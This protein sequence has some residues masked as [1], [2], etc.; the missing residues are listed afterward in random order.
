MIL[1]PTSAWVDLP[2]LAHAEVQ[3]AACVL[4]PVAGETTLPDEE[5]QCHAWT[6]R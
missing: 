6:Q 1:P 4:A 3:G 5:V 2:A